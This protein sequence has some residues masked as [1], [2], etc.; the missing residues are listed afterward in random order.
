MSRAATLLQGGA[1][2]LEEVLGRKMGW[3]TALNHL[4]YW[5]LLHKILDVAA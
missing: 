2:G 1:G 4:S 5:N 3:A